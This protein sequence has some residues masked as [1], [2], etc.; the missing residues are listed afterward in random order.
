MEL[1]REQK[2]EF[3]ERGFV[4]LPGIVPAEKVH[5]ARRAINASL[6]Q[7]GID[8]EQLT[9]FRSQTYCPE[10]TKTPVIT[11]LY[12]ETPIKDLAE[13]AVGVGKIRSVGYGQI[14]LRFPSPEGPP[15]EPEQDGRFRD[16]AGEREI[17][18]VRQ[19]LKPGS[20]RAGG[21]RPRP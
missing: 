13:S 17:D 12:N 9:K 16:D 11:D 20:G 21:E 19:H 5:A 2:Q 10:L 8:P 7:I 4:K 15:R 6:G 3:C 18:G 14:A 1:T